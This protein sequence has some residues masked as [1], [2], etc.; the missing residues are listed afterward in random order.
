VLEVHRRLKALDVS[1]KALLGLPAVKD[2]GSLV[3]HGTEAA[4]AGGGGGGGGGEGGKVVVGEAGFGGEPQ[5]VGIMGLDSSLSLGSPLE[6]GST[7]GGEL[8]L[9]LGGSTSLLMEGSHVVNSSGKVESKM[10]CVRPTNRAFFEQL[11]HD[12]SL[13]DIITAPDEPTGEEKQGVQRPRDGYTTGERTAGDDAEDVLAAIDELAATT[14]GA[15]TA[16]A[17]ETRVGEGGAVDAPTPA[18][19][20]RHKSFAMIL[21]VKAPQ[22]LAN[23]TTTSS[24][25]DDDDYGDD[26]DFEKPEGDAGEH[27][28][29]TLLQSMHRGRVTRKAIMKSKSSGGHHHGHDDQHKNNKKVVPTQ[30]HQRKWHGKE[31]HQPATMSFGSVNDH[32]LDSGSKHKFHSDISHANES[33]KEL[34][35]GKPRLHGGNKDP[36]LAATYVFCYTIGLPSFL[37]FDASLSL[38]L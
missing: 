5:Q 9:G 12:M 18:A 1:E 10:I 33:E 14:I 21:G 6:A 30:L 24:L 26:D 25:G 13:F 36:K 11:T 37:V 29:A 38:S 31:L 32:V 27:K 8:G 35:L 2:D 23:N 17:P 28:A 3:T 7:V 20:V 4:A 22:R 16:P 19:P 34:H 15:L